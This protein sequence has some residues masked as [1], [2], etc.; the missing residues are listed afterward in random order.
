M[1]EPIVIIH[2]VANRIEE[3]F[4]ESVAQLQHQ[5]GGE[6]ELLPV[7]WG[8]LGGVGTD[9]TDC[10]PVL[11]NGQWGVRGQAEQPLPLPRGLVDTGTLPNPARAELIAAAA[12]PAGQLVRSAATDATVQQVAEQ[13]LPATQILQH[14]DDEAVFRA[15]GE[16]I[17]AAVEELDGRA[18]DP[19]ESLVRGAGGHGVRGLLDPVGKVTKRLIHAVDDILGRTLSNRLGQFNQNLRAAVLPPLA[20]FF[21]DII[22]YQ[23]DQARIQ[24]RIWEA[25]ARHGGGYGTAAQPV[26]VV[27]HSLGG[28]ITFD[29]AVQKDNPLHLKS[30]TTFGS[31]AAFFHIVDQ[32]RT[33]DVYRQGQPVTLPATI[34]RW[35]NL[36]DTAD[37]LAF[38]ASTV[39]RLADGSRPQDVPVLDPLSRI[40]DEKAW[41]HSVYWGTQEL[42]QAIRETVAS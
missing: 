21:G 2:G 42:L 16:A 41:M 36:W 37:L 7:F 19:A 38:T 14:L 12:A 11:H 20:L 26:H 25:L 22:V 39:F 3:D 32:R 10:L 4:L 18:T 23:R 1:A 9:I 24:A 35:T 8:D 27:A 6:W 17:G 40:V 13:E 31:Q 29:A 34:R 30:F 5:L 28:V 15:L 33:L